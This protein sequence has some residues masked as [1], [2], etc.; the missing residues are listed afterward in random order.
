[1]KWR[2]SGRPIPNGGGAVPTREEL[3]R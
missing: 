3:D 1:V 2:D